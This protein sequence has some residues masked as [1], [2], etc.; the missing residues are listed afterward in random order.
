MRL[1]VF[2]RLPDISEL[3]IVVLRLCYSITFPPLKQNA[4][5]ERE[6]IV[7][8]LCVV[9]FFKKKLNNK[10]CKCVSG[11]KVS[12]C[13][14]FY[15]YYFEPCSDGHAKKNNFR[16][17]HVDSADRSRLLSETWSHLLSLMHGSFLT[18]CLFLTRVCN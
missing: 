16:D 7:F 17:K 6:E 14:L 5:L 11:G 1:L 10:D 15:Y 13:Q 18:L 12:T 2:A 3:T 8:S 4:I 9:L